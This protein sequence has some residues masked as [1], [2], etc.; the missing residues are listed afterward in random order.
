MALNTSK[1]NHLT[2]L[3]FKGLTEALCMRW[4]NWPEADFGTGRPRFL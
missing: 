2:P 1:C 3:P 4:Q